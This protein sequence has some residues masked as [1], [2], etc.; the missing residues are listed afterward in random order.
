MNKM[1][2]SVMILSLTAC[3]HESHPNLKHDLN[4]TLPI[5]WDR[6]VINRSSDYQ[7]R[8]WHH[9]HDPIL[10]QYIEQLLAKNTDIAMAALKVKQA[11][12][13]AGIS[14]TNLTPDVTASIAG[15]K[16]RTW[17]A[18]ENQ[19]NNPQQNNPAPSDYGNSNDT[20]KFSSSLTFSYELDLWGKLADTRK[21][22]HFEAQATAQDKEATALS[23]IGTAA[24]LYWKGCYLNE[25]LSINQQSLT[26][27][28]EALVIA[29]A[30]YRAGNS[31]ELDVLQAEQ[32]VATQQAE[33]ENTKHQID[34]NQYAFAILFDQPPQS[35][36]ELPSTL[37]TESLP[38]IP[39]IMPV[40]LLAQRPD[41]KAAE[42]RVRA[43]FATE[44]A[45]EKDYYPTFSL[46]SAFST[47]SNTLKNILKSPTGSFGGG[48]S[49][50]FLEWQN[51][52]LNI[53]TQKI[54]YQQSVLS[55]RQTLYTALSEV[56]TAFSERTHAVNQGDFY[57]LAFEK[58]RKA[59]KIASI[60]YQAGSIDMASWLEQQE[61][62]R[63][64]EKQVLENRL[65]QLTA[66]LDLYQ[67]LGGDSE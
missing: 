26:Y 14:D 48:L 54:I 12:L 47:S 30:K 57:K 25:L 44:S 64:I 8:W 22:S 42:L 59:E 39:V 49:L 21:A 2:L 18:S 37:S 1:I 40:S 5:A 50:P 56:E 60:R 15:A 9:F 7:K 65:N 52:K 20:N 28:Q 32:N 17:N 33:L 6:P 55:F 66:Q 34:A 53:D 24:S 27:T 4:L 3:S 51:R 31:N 43:Q 19:S 62:R 36:S 29:Q 61:A 13:A 38:A 45:T 35:T 46:S 41:V 58:A 67:A 23:L 11:Q 16:Q 63:T 10:N